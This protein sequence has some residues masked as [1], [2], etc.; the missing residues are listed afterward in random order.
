VEAQINLDSII[1]LDKSKLVEYNPHP[2]MVYPDIYIQ[3]DTFYIK[4]DTS[5]IKLIDPIWI[6]KVVILREKKFKKLFRDKTPI[7]M[8][9]P[10]KKFKNKISYLFLKK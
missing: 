7:L 4:L 1:N 3:I 6:K 10:K 8:I 9:Y 5:S 2:P